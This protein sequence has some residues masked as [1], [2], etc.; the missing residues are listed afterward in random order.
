M[1][2][3]QAFYHLQNRKICSFDL[4]KAKM[5]NTTFGSKGAEGWNWMIKIDGN[6]F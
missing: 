2:I 3:E 4:D 1:Q 5:N 6:N